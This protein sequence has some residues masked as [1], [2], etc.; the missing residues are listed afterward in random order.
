MKKLATGVMNTL[1]PLAEQAIQAE[2]G[3]KVD[4]GFWPKQDNNNNG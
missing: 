1:G 3:V 2:T 4:T